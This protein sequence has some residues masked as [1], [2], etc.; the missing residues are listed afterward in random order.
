M[1]ENLGLPRL[2]RITTELIN[3]LENPDE[4]FNQLESEQYH[5][6]LLSSIEG[7]RRLRNFGFGEVEAIDFIHRNVASEEVEKFTLVLSEYFPNIYGGNIVVNNDGSML[8]EAAEGTHIE[9]VH[10]HSTPTIF[11]ARD[12]FLKTIGIYADPYKKKRLDT[13]ELE[14]VFLGAIHSIP[15]DQLEDNGKMGFHPGYYEFVVVRKGK[16]L[17]PLF[18]DFRDRGIYQMRHPK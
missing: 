11:G 3:F 10:G 12:P 17:V 15:K 9:L 2:K 4:Y 8:L 14:Q 7:K 18:I 13:P 6:S 1:L 16:M 5:V